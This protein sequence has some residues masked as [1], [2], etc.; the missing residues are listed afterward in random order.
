MPRYTWKKNCYQLQKM[1]TIE[2]SVQEVFFQTLAP[3]G[4]FLPLPFLSFRKKTNTERCKTHK[5]K[6][7][8][9]S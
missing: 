7:E 5:H 4:L 8:N 3:K 1:N 9:K 6:K 2:K